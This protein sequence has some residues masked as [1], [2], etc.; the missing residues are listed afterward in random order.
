M[1]CCISGVPPIEPVV[2][3]LTGCLFEKRLIEK[4]LAEHGRCP[5]TGEPM[6]PDDLVRV[7][8]GAPTQGVATVA[9]AMGSIP[10]L[11]QALH[12]EW[13]SVMLEQFSLRQR[14]SQAQ[15]ELAQALFQY[16]AAERVTA[17]LI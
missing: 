15:H 7:S 2:S 8:S 6:R 17:R 16:D 5:K 10:A 9:G 4:Y 13:D 1:F 11:L 14:L 3:K 12:H